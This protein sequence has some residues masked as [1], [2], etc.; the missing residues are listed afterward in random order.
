MFNKQ[1][2][3]QAIKTLNFHVKFHREKALTELSEIYREEHKN[4]ALATQARITELEQ[5][6]TTVN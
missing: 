1:E 5:L 2:I 4:K 6:L 3:E